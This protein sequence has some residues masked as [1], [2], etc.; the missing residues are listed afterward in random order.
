M[1]SPTRFLLVNRTENRKTGPI[2]VVYSSRDS[3]PPS[4]PLR[5]AGCYAENY[6]TRGAWDRTNASLETLVAWIQDLPAGTLWRYGVAGDL[7]GNGESIDTI[8]LRLIMAANQGR[9]GFAYSHKRPAVA[10]NRAAIA[11]ANRAGFTINLSADS[12]AE[13]DELADHKCGPVVV[14]LP[15]DTRQN[16]VTPAG[17]KVVICPA[18]T[19]GITC[20]DC[21][22]CAK[23]ARSYIVGF[24][25]HGSLASKITQR[26]THEIAN[27]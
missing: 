3:C 2:P 16:T 26:L 19:R 21:R 22:F 10:H 25:A 7:P 27:P 17:R 6:P 18:I 13:A 14:V 24:P 23:S 5:G 11:A 9:H 8:A 4:C 15:R 20:A 1:K 12:L